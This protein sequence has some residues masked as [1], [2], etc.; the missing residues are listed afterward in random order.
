MTG[1][2][3][4]LEESPLDKLLKSESGTTPKEILA[5]MGEEGHELTDDQLDEIA[6]GFWVRNTGAQCPSCHSSNVAPQGMHSYKCC[7]CQHVFTAG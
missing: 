7:D 5:A 1:S 6:G 4:T 2:P 3:M